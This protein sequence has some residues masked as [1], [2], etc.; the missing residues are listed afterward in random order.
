MTFTFTKVKTRDSYR[1]PGIPR[2][3]ELEG[4]LIKVVEVE[5]RW[6]E[7]Y[8]D[9]SW[10]PMEYFR[11][12]TEDN[13]RFVLRYSTLFKSWGIRPETDLTPSEGT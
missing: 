9:S 5:R 7:A 1:V 2:F 6:H 11:I 10:Y 8:L 4:K 3:V 12:R 13:R